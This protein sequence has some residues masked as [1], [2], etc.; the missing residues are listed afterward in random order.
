M[1]IIEAIWNTFF[2]I[3]MLACWQSLTING[4]HDVAKI[5]TDVVRQ[6]PAKRIRRKRG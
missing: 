6:L 4:K 3:V 1:R 2:S 5:V